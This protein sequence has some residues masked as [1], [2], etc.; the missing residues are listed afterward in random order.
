MITDISTRHLQ[1]TQ[2]YQHLRLAKHHAAWI[3]GTHYVGV[4]F[5]SMPRCL[6]LSRMLSV[7][8]PL[9]LQ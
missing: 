1:L 9:A 2:H 5:S 3:Q 6:A 8:L 4:R 7:L